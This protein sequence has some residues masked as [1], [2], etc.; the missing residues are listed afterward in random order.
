[1]E[2]LRAAYGLG[3]R[4]RGGSTPAEPARISVGRNIDR[5]AAHAPALAAHLR[6]PVRTGSF[7]AY[8]PDPAIAVRWVVPD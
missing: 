2:R 6:A 4:A 1:M 5:V 8:E 3:G 7:C